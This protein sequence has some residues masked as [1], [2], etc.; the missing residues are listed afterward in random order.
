MVDNLLFS[1][2]PPANPTAPT[3][4]QSLPDSI[5][6][7]ANEVE[8]PDDP[9]PL[10]T[11]HE[12]AVDT[13]VEN[14]AVRRNGQLL[15]TINSLNQVIQVDPFD[16]NRQPALVHTFPGGAAGIIE[17]EEDV[18]Y[19]TSGIANKAG[20]G[21]IF[22]IDMA[23]FAADS[24]GN[25]Q[26]E[27]TVTKLLD[28][29]DALFLNGA[30]LLNRRRGIILVSDSVLGLVYRIDVKSATASIF[31]QDKLLLSANPAFPGVNGIKIFR[32]SLYLA[33]LQS[34]QFLCAGI[35]KGG[36]AT[37]KVDVLQEKLTIDDF[38]FDQDGSAFMTTHIFNSVVQLCPNGERKRI[39]GGLNNTVVAGTTAGAF[40]RTKADRRRLYV[41][42]EGGI[43]NPIQN[44]I[45]PGRVLA[46]D[47]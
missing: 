22:R 2:V 35:T 34:R 47:I 16:H 31:L 38:V 24:Q 26:T 37:G 11:I 33:N 45:G 6:D 7:L 15:V 12:F 19:V 23:A 17:V 20:T 40:G 42:T 25:V 27:A 32:G 14:I 9:R 13:F 3:T 10:T 43:V 4:P 21:S 30:T 36:N 8:G 5:L 46:I 1:A 18:F 29:P 39:A 28:L 41:T 44:K